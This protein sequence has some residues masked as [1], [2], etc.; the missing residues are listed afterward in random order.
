MENSP[1]EFDTPDFVR[2][3]FWPEGF[4]VD[5]WSVDNLKLLADE[6]END[7][8]LVPIIDGAAHIPRVLSPDI[9]A[10]RERLLRVFARQAINQCDHYADDARGNQRKVELK[11]GMSALGMSRRKLSKGEWNKLRI[12]TQGILNQRK[13]LMDAQLLVTEAEQTATALG[14]VGQEKWPFKS[15]SA[16][17]T[18]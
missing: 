13:K 15:A 7:T 2:R 11:E 5:D 4:P 8:Y 10:N 1:Q 6:L 17:N 18:K 9:Q 16:S 14:D 3:T 12:F